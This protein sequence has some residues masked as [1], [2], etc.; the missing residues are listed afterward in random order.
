MGMNWDNYPSLFTYHLPHSYRK[1]GQ[2]MSCQYSNNYPVV[3]PKTALAMSL[4]TCSGNF[5]RSRSDVL[6]QYL[7][8]LTACNIISWLIEHLWTY[9][10][11]VLCSGASGVLF[12]LACG[13]STTSDG[14]GDGLLFTFGGRFGNIGPDESLRT[15]GNFAAVGMD[16]VIVVVAVVVV[17]KSSRLS[18]ASIWPSLCGRYLRNDFLMFFIDFTTASYG[19][20]VGWVRRFSLENTVLQIISAFVSLVWILKS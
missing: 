4:S 9:L 17:K 20:T 3:L 19:V 16:P 14:T 5:L 1:C 2:Q 18:K 15:L 10:P 13:Y 11:H 12:S 6:S 7:E 8:V